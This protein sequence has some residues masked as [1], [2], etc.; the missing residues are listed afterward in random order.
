MLIAL[1]ESVL[2]VLLAVISAGFFSILTDYGDKKKVWAGH[3]LPGPHQGIFYLCCLPA[4]LLCSL[5]Q[6]QPPYGLPS[7]LG[8]IPLT[9]GVMYGT[10][11][12]SFVLAASALTGVLIIAQSI[13]MSP[14]YVGTAFILFPFMLLHVKFFQRGTLLDKKLVIF[15]YV[16]ADMLL[17]A[18]LPLLWG[19]QNIS[20][21][22]P[23]LLTTFWNVAVG[24]L[25][26]FAVVSLMHNSFE[27]LTL[28]RDVTEF[29]SKYLIEVDK[30]RQV[31]DLMPLSLV[32]LDSEERV[33]HMNKTMLELYRD[34]DPFITLPEV[35]GRPLNTLY[36]FS[37]SPVVN[38]RVAKALEGEAGADFINVSPKVFFSSFLP[39]RDKHMNQTTGVIIALQ[40]ITE[41]ETLRSELGNF[42]RLS[43]VGQMAAGI[44]HEIRNPM[45]VVRGFLQLM[46]EKSPDSL[47]HYYRIVMEELDRANGIINDFLSLA[48]NRIVEKEQCHL[49]DIIRELTPLLWA[50]A[51]LRGQTIE[52]KLEDHVTMLHLNPKEIKQLLLNLSRNAMEAMGEKG[53]LTI[54]THEEGDFVELEV[55]DTGPGIPPKQL[56]KLFQPFYTTKTKGT[57]LGLALCQSIVERHHGT[58]AV[59]SVEGMGTQF[60]VRLRRT[61]PT[62]REHSEPPVINSIQ[63]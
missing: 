58:I 57:G 23:D 6:Y 11:R 43:L 15:T 60:K 33:I 51:N 27:K 54:S 52:L 10:R 37:A 17:K 53:V 13:E 2:Q 16:V 61:I 25:A 34:F 21:Y 29:T 20:V 50:D 59:D 49:H 55:R 63:K 48:Q 41:L 38:E 5:F 12:T 40:D 24:V 39:F 8:I 7:N 19:K 30:L 44:T 28:R 18:L 56:E 14:M 31:M 47:G 3:L 1:K 62:Y 45:A 9:V 4:I 42:E 32:T 26:S 36:G 35:V 46:R 22:I